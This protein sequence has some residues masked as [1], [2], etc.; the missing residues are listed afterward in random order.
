[1]TLTC[2]S[3]PK[4]HLFLKILFIYLKGGKE[5]AH[6][7]TQVW[8]G[9]KGRKTSRLLPECRAWLG[10]PSQNRNQDLSPNQESGMGSCRQDCLCGAKRP[11]CMSASVTLTPNSNLFSQQPLPPLL[12]PPMPC[13][14][15]LC[16]LSTISTI[17][18]LFFI[19]HTGTPSRSHFKYNNLFSGENEL[20]EES[21]DV[22]PAGNQASLAVIVC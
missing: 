17:T 13:H 9:R 12:A 5:H 19:T 20:C 4:S 15:F 22:I 3:F 10:A 14:C 18:W 8:V 16:T 2:F 21:L 6:A 11:N 7:H 1:M